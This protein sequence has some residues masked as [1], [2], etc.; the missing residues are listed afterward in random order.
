M[1]W[2]SLNDVPLG[3]TVRE[4]PHPQQEGQI[5]YQK[6]KTKYNRYCILH[7]EETNQFHIVNEILM[8]L[9]ENVHNRLEDILQQEY[10]TT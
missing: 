2:E 4:I 9:I 1:I 3:Y 6:V 10:S 7:D 5:A 8:N